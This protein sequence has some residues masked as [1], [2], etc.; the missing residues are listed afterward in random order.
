MSKPTRYQTVEG[1]QITKLA[2]YGKA[3]RKYGKGWEEEKLEQLFTLLEQKA[4]PLD[5]SAIRAELEE[6]ARW[7]T[8]QS[9]TPPANRE[10]FLRT[11]HL[12]LEMS[13]QVPRL[14]QTLVRRGAVCHVE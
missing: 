12:H 11:A 3:K 10:A 4:E 5:E 2:C 8:K 7:L 6:S 9:T 13:L 14:L 1:A